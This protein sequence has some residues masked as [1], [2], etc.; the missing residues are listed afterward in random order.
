M[1]EK[2]NR[3]R[4]LERK[5]RQICA[6]KEKTDIH[7]ERINALALLALRHQPPV[8]LDA[9]DLADAVRFEL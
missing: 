8:L 4:C 6:K 1:K 3:S 5:K 2:N 7:E 9:D